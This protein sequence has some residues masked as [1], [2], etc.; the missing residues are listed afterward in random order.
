[1]KMDSSNHDLGSHQ[2]PPSSTPKSSTAHSSGSNRSCCGNLLEFFADVIQEIKPA[3]LLEIATTIRGGEFAAITID[4]PPLC[5]SYNLVY[6]IHFQDGVKWCARVP[7]HASP[8]HFGEAQ[9]QTMSVELELLRYIHKKTSVPIAQIRHY[10]TTFDNP[11]GAPFSLISWIDGKP[12]QEVWFDT[13]SRVPLKERRLRILKSLAQAMAQLSSV[14]FPLIGVPIVDND[15]LRVLNTAPLRG[16]DDG[17]ELHYLVEGSSENETRNP[18]VFF[19]REPFES[20]AEY[21]RF[22]LNRFKLSWEEEE[23]NCVGDRDDLR[24]AKRMMEIIIDAIEAIEMGEHPSKGQRD[25]AGRFVLCHP[26]F[27]FQNCRVADDGTL[28]GLIDWDGI[29]TT[30]KHLGYA[31]YP[32]WLVRDW[33]PCLF[34]PGPEGD[35]IP[36]IRELRRAYLGFMKEQSKE[37]AAATANSHIYRAVEDACRDKHSLLSITDKIARVCLGGHL[38]DVKFELDGEVLTYG[39]S[40]DAKPDRAMECG[41]ESEKTNSSFMSEDKGD[42]VWDEDE[43]HGVESALA[44][45]EVPSLENFKSIQL[46]SPSL[47]DQYSPTVG[48]A[49]RLYRPFRHTLHAFRSFRATLPQP[50]S[51]LTHV[52]WRL[53]GLLGRFSLHFGSPARYIRGG[54]SDSNSQPHQGTQ[55]HAGESVED[56]LLSQDEQYS[57]I[58][59]REDIDIKDSKLHAA[60]LE[61]IDDQKSSEHDVKMED[62]QSEVSESSEGSERSYALEEDE[63]SEAEEDKVEHDDDGEHRTGAAMSVD[64]V[65]SEGSYV[66]DPNE[67]VPEWLFEL[68]MALGQETVTE[69]QIGTLKARFI[70][71]FT[72]EEAVEE[73]SLK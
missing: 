21:L 66:P 72:S 46:P 39:P 8:N 12:V 34:E 32:A 18:F 69:E 68:N 20:T 23:N 43:L 57:E 40:K 16:R 25:A 71:T 45:P 15:T 1:M 65:D 47:E 5:G 58:D 2:G 53:Q 6:V 7:Q 36:D 50:H 37:I 70:E 4:D 44:S 60:Q 24:G 73:W 41:A 35:S 48:W 22:W 61:V 33:R 11:F 28:L 30:S 3:A 13:E 67:V 55:V 64:E 62:A 42:P 31:A 19:E 59:G 38:F 54:D 49:T 63:L 56:P 26:D 52:S 29:H 27:N 14:S 9:A 51:L 17:L 10:D